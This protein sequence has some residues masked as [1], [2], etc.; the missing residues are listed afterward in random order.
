VVQRERRD[1]F[2][3]H[4]IGCTKLELT[5]CFI[6]H[7]DAAGVG[8]GQLHRLGDDGIEYGFQVERGIHR[9]AD[10]TESLKFLDRFREFI[11]S[12]PRLVEQ[13]HVLDSNHGLIGEGLQ[14]FDVANRKRTRLIAGDNDRADR[15]TR[16]Q[17]RDREDAPPIAGVR[18]FF[19]VG[20]IS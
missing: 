2:L 3:A 17:H 10:L 14:Q 19:V 5:A 9:L 20:W 11:G 7:V 8:A 18:D 16:T 15:R 12:S 13:A 1:Q 4:A 6:E